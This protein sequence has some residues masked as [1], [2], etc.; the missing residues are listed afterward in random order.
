MGL[1]WSLAPR[2]H[3]RL[4]NL[5]RIS[6]LIHIS[7]ISRFEA[8][9]SLQI[10]GKCT[11]LL[12]M[13]LNKLREGVVARGWRCA[14][15]NRSVLKRKH[16]LLLFSTSCVL[17]L[18]QD[19]APAQRWSKGGWQDSRSMQPRIRK[20]RLLI[21]HVLDSCVKL[22]AVLHISSAQDRSVVIHG[23]QRTTDHPIAK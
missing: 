11:E 10:V 14:Q 18:C 7:K 13:F 17:G 9:H 15:T 23:M 8:F 2:K 19:P 1:V 16:L 12:K 6:R 5:F 3:S 4:V 21:T 22:L 20:A